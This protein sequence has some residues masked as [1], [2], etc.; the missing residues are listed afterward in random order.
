[1]CYTL[2]LYSKALHLLV[3]LPEILSPPAFASFPA[4]LSNS[5]PPPLAAYFSS[6]PPPPNFESG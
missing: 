4:Y 1:M 5:P 2:S 3:P 6:P